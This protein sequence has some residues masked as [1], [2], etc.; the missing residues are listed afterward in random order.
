MTVGGVTTSTVN[1][2]LM[3]ALG[4]GLATAIK[5]RNPL[6][7][8]FE[9][10]AFAALIPMIFVQIYGIFVY[11]FVEAKEVVEIVVEASISEVAEI[12]LLSV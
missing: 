8:G 11:N 4:I 5:G 2:P 3:A 9:L 12:T 7:D 10:I 1:V 6:L